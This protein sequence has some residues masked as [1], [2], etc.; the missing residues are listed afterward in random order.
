MFLCISLSFYQFLT[1]FPEVSQSFFWSSSFGTCLFFLPF[2]PKED[3]LHNVFITLNRTQV[4]LFPSDSATHK[5]FFN[6]FSGE[7]HGFSHLAAS[8][9]HVFNMCLL[10]IPSL[11]LLPLIQRHYFF[12]RRTKNLFS[13]LDMDKV[14][15]GSGRTV[16]DHT[17]K[18]RGHKGETRIQ[19]WNESMKAKGYR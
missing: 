18:Q 9:L 14:R 11:L 2:C 13:V 6:P 10:L 17:G 19:G 1:C 15:P 4:L 3:P 12:N 8:P 5:V 7:A 16:A